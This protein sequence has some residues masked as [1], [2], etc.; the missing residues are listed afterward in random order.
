MTAPRL[1]AHTCEGLH[2]DFS[3]GAFDYFAL[4]S[5]DRSSPCFRHFWQ[6]VLRR[7]GQLAEVG[8]FAEAARQSCRALEVL[9][10]RSQSTHIP[11]GRCGFSTD[12]MIL[13]KE[14]GWSTQPHTR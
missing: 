3:T 14:G 8:L 2:W 6:T 10:A 11:F 7:V 5:G 4:F 1:C 12:G 13:E 9:H